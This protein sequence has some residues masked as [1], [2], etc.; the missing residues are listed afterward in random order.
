MSL[1]VPGR[2][3]PGPTVGAVGPALSED[4]LKKRIIDTAMLYGWRVCHVRPARKRNGTWITPIEGHAG[5]PDLVL[6]RDGQVLL[7][8]LKSER[9]KP[10]A[11]Q[12]AWLEAAG[13]NGHLWHPSDWPAALVLL[14]TPR[15]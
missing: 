11:D 6:A 10:T 14:S 8:E 3:T 7:V 12:L 2:A 13:D 1:L 4:Q 9:G 15:G 5:L